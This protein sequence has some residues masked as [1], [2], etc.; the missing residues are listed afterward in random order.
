MIR[1]KPNKETHAYQSNAAELFEPFCA[2]KGSCVAF[3]FFAIFEMITL[4][5]SYFMIHFKDFGTFVII[6]RVWFL[7]NCNKGPEPAQPQ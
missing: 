2:N 3:F 7:F 6:F 4:H 1:F 5:Q